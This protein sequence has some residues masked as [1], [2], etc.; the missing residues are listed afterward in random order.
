MEHKHSGQDLRLLEQIAG[1]SRK[2]ESTFFGSGVGPVLSPADI[3]KQFMEIS[4]KK[5]SLPLSS[6]LVLGFLA[7]AFIA[8]AAQ[9]STVIASDVSQFG[10]QRLVAGS[11]FATGLMLVI[12]AGGE[13]FTGNSLMTVGLFSGTISFRE[14]LRNWVTVYAGNFLGA[15]ALAGL[16][17]SSGL[18]HLNGA[19]VG[20]SVVNTA[21]GKVSM[22]FTEALARGVLCN[23]LVCLAVW[24]ATGAQSASGKI[25]GIFFPIMLFVASGFEHSIA[26]MYY[27][28][29]GI[30]A[31]HDPKIAALPAFP[32]QAL[33]TGNLSWGGFLAKNLLPVTLGNIIGGVLFV[34]FLYWAVYVRPAMGGGR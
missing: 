13:L 26:N 17:N 25:L 18:W 12:L 22:S 4:K 27:I 11:S 28:P 9:G 10:I 19:K 5:A 6:M 16:M 34:G 21:L 24:I 3:A 32:S 23:W 7:G 8:L 31:A 15:L 33:A 2:I 14:L 1:Y 29:A 20:L 30:L